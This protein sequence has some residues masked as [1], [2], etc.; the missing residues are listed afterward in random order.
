MKPLVTNRRMLTWLCLYPNE[1]TST[2]RKKI[3]RIVFSVANFIFVLSFFASSVAYLV[4]FVS[5][6]LRHSLYALLQIFGGATV[7]YILVIAFHLRHK[8]PALRENLSQIYQECKT[9]VKF[10]W[11]I[12]VLSCLQ[13]NRSPFVLI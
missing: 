13:T 1:E 6:D 5:I 8:F 10:R 4:E 12:F 9:L 3:A 7:L 2:N 11:L